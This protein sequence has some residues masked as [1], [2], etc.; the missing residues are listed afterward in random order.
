LSR[1]PALSSIPLSGFALQQS[2]NFAGKTKM[3]QLDIWSTRDITRRGFLTGIF[4]K[5]PTKIVLA[6]FWNMFR[7]LAGDTVAKKNS[8]HV[9]GML[10]FEMCDT[11]IAKLYL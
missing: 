1:A 3:G 7:N 8:Q 11:S 4:I 2:S 10:A 5:Q 9:L 6:L